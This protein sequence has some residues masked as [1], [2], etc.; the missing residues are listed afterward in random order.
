MLNEKNGILDITVETAVELDKNFTE[1]LV[2]I[3]KEK[4]G[5]AGVKIKTCIKPE[6]LGGFLLRTGG[7]YIDAS[8]KGQ[9]E[10]MMAELGSFCFRF[11]ETSVNIT[12]NAV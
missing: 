12:A 7:F 10:K 2:Q 5:A 6:L 3:I 1:E 4:T 9:V 8:L 11:A